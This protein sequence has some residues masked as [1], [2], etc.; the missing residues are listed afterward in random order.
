MEPR[1]L[2]RK[3]EELYTKLNLNNQSRSRDDL[4]DAMIQYP[5]LI[6]RPIVINHKKIALGRLPE[7]ILEIL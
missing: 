7:S 2:I 4:I 5:I 6:E 3:G 1:D